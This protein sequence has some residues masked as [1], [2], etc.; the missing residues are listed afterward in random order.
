MSLA[1]KSFSAAIAAPLVLA[2]GLAGGA[3][4][5]DVDFGCRKPGPAVAALQKQV[6]EQ[7]GMI[8]VGVRPVAISNT[9]HE[10]ETI[11]LNLNTGKGLLWEKAKDGTVCIT[12]QY[13]N[14]AIFEH[15]GFDNRAFTTI[16][17]RDPRSIDVNLR[18][19]N[20]SVGE[21]KQNPMFRAEAYVPTNAAKG[22]PVRY[23]VRYI[24]YMSG[25][26][27]TEKGTVTAASLD[28]KVLSDFTKAIPG[29]GE[30]SFAFGAIHTPAGKD[31]L[32][33]T[34]VAAAPA[35]GT[36]GTYALNKP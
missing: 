1:Q 11:M 30:S 34:R 17:G 21:Q 6:L 32:M 8:P 16:Q 14:G 13:T 5:A 26:P 22:D 28:G 36:A 27:S 29:K 33:K 25:N 7:E 12:S 2:F 3:A 10:Q 35:I 4:H 23:P 18:I 20:L 9:E 31:Y 24:E 19:A 15:T